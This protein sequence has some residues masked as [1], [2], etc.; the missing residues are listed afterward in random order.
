M[1]KVKTVQATFSGGEV[2]EGFE[3]R[4]DLDAYYKSARKIRNCYIDN[5]GYATR[6]EGL[7]YIAGTTTNQAARLIPFSFNT[8]QSYLIVFTPGEFKVYRDD[9]LQATVTSSPISSLTAAQIDEMDFVQSADTLIIVHEDFNPIEITRTS[10]T[11]WTAA[12]ISFTNMIQRTYIDTAGSGTNEIMQINFVQTTGGT[13][14]S[15]RIKLEGEETQDIEWVTADTA[16]S[17][18]T[19]IEN[20]LRALSNTSATG[21]TVVG[22]TVK[23]HTI[24]FGGDDGARNWVIPELTARQGFDSISIKTTTQGAAPVEDVW[25]ASRGWPKTATFFEGRL[26]FGGNTDAPQSAWG[27]VVNDFYN[28]NVGTGQADQAINITIDDDQVNAITGVIAGR[29]LQIFTTGGEFA[30]IKDVDEPITPDNLLLRKQTTHGSKAVRPVSIDGSTIFVEGSGRVVREF[31]FNDVEQSYTAP[32]VTVLSPDVTTDVTRMGVR[33]ST[34]DN[35]SSVTYMVNTDGTCAVLNKLKEQNLRA[36]SAFTT[37]GDFEDVAVVGT[38]VYFVV[39][40][41]INSS[42]VRYIEKLNKTH[43]LDASSVQSSGGGTDTW[44]GLAHLNG[45]ASTILVGVETDD[46]LSTHQD[47]T[48]S[49]GSVTTDFNV[50]EFEAGLTFLA[51]IE[52]LPIEALLGNNQTAGDKKRAVYANCRLRDTRDLQ[53]Q[54]GRGTYKP[55]FRNHGS[56]LLD[57]PTPSFTGWK[58]V[59]T[60]GVGRDLDYIITQEQPLEFEVL[61]VV[62]GVSL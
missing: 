43:L 61:A 5:L 59:Y 29:T 31:V 49:A 9:S 51:R 52:L 2:G 32:D 23:R 30:F 26:W 56:L 13:Q 19:K 4:I 41:S 27:S 22:N 15:F 46:Q 36:F 57:Q 1:P 47:L 35:S 16:A 37:E 33:R 55:S 44:T 18:A 8:E 48:P 50:K 40:R 34:A 17:L 24:T 6:R 60:K 25:S 21:I 38:D 62:I 58:K 14:A 53:V 11:T 10:H 42:T 28:F 3:G 12:N 7:E 20:A 54:V 45:E 39:E